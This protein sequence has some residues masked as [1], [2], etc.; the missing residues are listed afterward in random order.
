MNHQTGIG[1]APN[2]L[3]YEY[4]RYYGDDGNGDGLTG[5]GVRGCDRCTDRRPKLIHYSIAESSRNMCFHVL[6]I[7]G[8]KWLE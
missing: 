8:A 5:T 3:H 7:E 1:V 4:T 6:L 2:C